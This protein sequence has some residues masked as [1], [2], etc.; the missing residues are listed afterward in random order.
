MRKHGLSVT[1]ALLS[2]ASIVWADSPCFLLFV[3]PVPPSMSVEST[4]WTLGG[5]QARQWVDEQVTH[6][7]LLLLSSGWDPRGAHLHVRRS[8]HSTRVHVL[9]AV[10]YPFGSTA[11]SPVHTIHCLEPFQCAAN[12]YLSVCR[13]N[14]LIVHY[15]PLGSTAHSL[16]LALCSLRIIRM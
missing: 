13:A 15:C 4:L 5:T 7:H 2:M 1:P 14:T 10:H 16:C 11:H 6:T 9:L 8:S 3:F 12:T